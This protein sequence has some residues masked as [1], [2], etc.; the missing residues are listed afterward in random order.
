MKLTNWA[1]MSLEM[2]WA[3]CVYFFIFFSLKT[4]P[5]AVIQKKWHPFSFILLSTNQ[6]TDEF[7]EATQ[8]LSSERIPR[9]SSL[10]LSATDLRQA[11]SKLNV[12]SIDYR[13]M[14]YITPVEDQVGSSKL[15]SVF[16]W[17]PALWFIYLCF[18]SFQETPGAE[19]QISFSGLALV[20]R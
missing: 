6:T 8:A 5:V 2:W 10:M 3:D 13:D 9:S 12:R 11:A 14:G 16:M 4:V 1:W 19:M 20:K 17:L 15:T 18:N 7:V